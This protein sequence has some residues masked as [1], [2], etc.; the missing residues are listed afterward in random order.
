MMTPGRK[1]CMEGLVSASRN[2]RAGTN[3]LVDKF[4]AWQAILSPD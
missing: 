4:N 2:T 1:E 3:K